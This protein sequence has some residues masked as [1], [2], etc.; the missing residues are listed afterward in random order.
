MHERNQCAANKNIK[1]TH[2]L[3]S[4]G[5]VQAAATTA[6][7]AIYIKSGFF[8]NASVHKTPANVQSAGSVYVFCTNHPAR[9]MW[10]PDGKHTTQRG[11]HG[12]T[13]Q[14]LR[15]VQVLPVGEWPLWYG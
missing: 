5:A 2:T 13:V 7:G 11:V 8:S 3:P 14:R 12:C 1:Y 9:H 10:M 4:A 15:G 6:L